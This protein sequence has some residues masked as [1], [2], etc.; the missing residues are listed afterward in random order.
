ME[1]KERVLQIRSFLQRIHGDRDGYAYVPY[2]E[3]NEMH[4]QG[5]KNPSGRDKHAN[6]ITAYSPHRTSYY[7]PALFKSRGSNA[8]S[9]FLCSKFLWL[10]VD[11]DNGDK[12]LKI[13]SNGIAVP[14]P[15]IIVQSSTQG[16]VHLY[17]ELE[18]WLDDVDVLERLNRGI[19]QTIGLSLIDRTSWDAGQLLRIPGTFNLKTKEKLPVKIVKDET[20]SVFNLSVFPLDE[21]TDSKYEHVLEI[22]FENLPTYEDALKGHTLHADTLFSLQMEYPK[23]RSGKLYRIAHDLVEQTTMTDTEIYA[24]LLN[25]DNYWGKY[26]GDDRQQTELTKLIVKA[27]N[28]QLREDTLAEDFPAITGHDLRVLNTIKPQFIYEGFIAEKRLVTLFGDPSIG[29]TRLAMQLA[30]CGLTRVPF[31]GF[32]FNEHVNIRPMLLTM[33]MATD[34]IG[35]YFEN[36]IL[37]FTKEEQELLLRD[38]I[39]IPQARET[40]LTK[41]Q[42]QELLVDRLKKHR[43]NFL[44][45]DSIITSGGESDRIR[46][47]YN[48]ASSLRHR[49]RC[50]VV[51]ISHNRKETPEAPRKTNSLSDLFGS[52]EHSARV[53]TVIA[54][55]RVKGT[56]NL[57]LTN[58][59]TR[60]GKKFEPII[61]QDTSTF[62]YQ[63]VKEKEE[64]PNDGPKPTDKFNT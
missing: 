64:K 38:F 1:L 19:A 30:A 43:T 48:F 47:Y 41:I 57:E 21:R 18:D 54:V 26:E 61:I 10:D 63:R 52:F 15:S 24:V 29:K 27:R 17:W 51:F 22:D 55:N 3:N 12:V 56:S 39:F 23:D 6:A 46:D 2:L 11:H 49:L 33:E 16:N 44:I 45:I 7:S 60:D 25:R 32:E 20:E 13:L 53:D 28:K 8:R 58:P 36:L 9:N 50:E 62:W 5:Y 4:P 34:L 35:N 40:N 59:K 31:L 42:D 37:N 14:S